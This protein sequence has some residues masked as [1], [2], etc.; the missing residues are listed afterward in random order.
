MKENFWNK[1]KWC[2]RYTKEDIYLVLFSFLFRYLWCDL[3]IKQN[4]IGTIF[5]LIDTYIKNNLLSFDPF[6]D[7]KCSK[8]KLLPV[9]L[10]GCFHDRLN[11][12]FGTCISFKANEETYIKYIS[13]A[14]V[15]NT[16]KAKE[17]SE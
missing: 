4:S 7:E 13:Q 9:C 11:A 15:N 3:G 1:I 16:E 6:S 17:I 8:C 2:W 5:E 14:L 12:I 10:G